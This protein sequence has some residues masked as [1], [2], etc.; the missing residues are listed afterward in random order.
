MKLT[1]VVAVLAVTAS[2]ANVAR[3]ENPSITLKVPDV[4]SKI[5]SLTSKI[6]AIASDIAANPDAAASKIVSQATSAASD[7]ASIGNEI[8][9]KIGDK[10]NAITSF[11][12]SAVADGITLSIPSLPT[13]SIDTQAL[14]SYITSIQSKFEPSFVSSIK[15]GHTPAVVS[16]F[17]DSLPTEYKTVAV[18]AF[19]KA[20]ENP[21]PKSDTGSTAGTKDAGGSA[22]PSRGLTGIMAAVVVGVAGLAVYL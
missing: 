22:A 11:I 7:I 19:S 4:N 3:Q 17:I 14:N 21:A 5:D 2:A 6:D 18:V 9:S 15:A 13:K 1:A 8:N 10:V 16:Q 20:A 12:G